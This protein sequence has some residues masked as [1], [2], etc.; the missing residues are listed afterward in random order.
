MRRS[1]TFGLVALA[2]SVSTPAAEAQQAPLTFGFG[3]AANVPSQ[4]VGFGA[5]VLFPLW[6]GTGLYADMKFDPSSPDREASFEPELTHEQAA[7]FGDRWFQD[8]ASW[9]TLN[10]GLIH[11]FT[12]ELM[13]YAGAGYAR[14]RAFS[15][16]YDDRIPPERG[17]RGY[18]WIEDPENHGD[19][20]NFFGGAFLRVRAGLWVQF[21][22]EAAPPGVT[23]GLSL[24]FPRT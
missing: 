24:S 3:Y 12:D 5:H 18:Y 14:R 21:G 16:Y 10:L 19:G 15:E 6:G 11:R 17:D 9:R 7:A 22:A 8:Q 20:V 2:V 13:V 1:F 23:L 4:A